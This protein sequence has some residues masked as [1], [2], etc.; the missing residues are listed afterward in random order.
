MTNAIQHHDLTAKRLGEEPDDAIVLTQDDY[1]GNEPNAVLLHPSQLRNVCEQF[2]IIQFGI[3]ASDPQAAKTIAMLQRRLLAL[4]DRVDFLANYLCNHSDHKHADL[5]FEMTYA[6]ATADIAAEFVAD[7]AG[8]CVANPASV[9]STA[10]GSP[11]S[12]PS[13]APIQAQAASKP[14]KATNPTQ[15]ELTSS[16]AA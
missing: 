12:M 16:A 2:G 1:S 10:K 5:N 15:L 3:I 11:H 14:A 8:D 13:N 6:N 7:F 9:P 4:N